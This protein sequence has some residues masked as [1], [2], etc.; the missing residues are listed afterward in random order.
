MKKFLYIIAIA[1]AAFSFASCNGN[2]ETSSKDNADSTV[3]EIEDLKELTC[4]NYS[5]AIPADWRQ[6]ANW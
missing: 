4:D 6:A 3:T 2:S 5:I 1:S